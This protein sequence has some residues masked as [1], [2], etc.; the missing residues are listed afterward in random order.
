MQ[1]VAKTACPTPRKR[2]SVSHKKAILGRSQLQTQDELACPRRGN[3]MHLELLQRY[4]AK[5]CP[6]H[7]TEREERTRTRLCTFLEQKRAQAPPHSLGRCIG[8]FGPADKNLIRN[9]CVTYRNCTRVVY[10]NYL[11]C[12][13][14]GYLC[15]RAG[16]AANFGAWNLRES[17]GVRGNV[18]TA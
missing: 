6:F 2:E 8:S 18:Q 7:T 4:V 5:A 1:P 14:S 15:G 16:L 3:Y 11:V 17:R 13:K 12:L 10:C 9:L